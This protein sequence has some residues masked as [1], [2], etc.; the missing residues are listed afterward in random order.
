[1]KTLNEILINVEKPSRYIGGEYGEGNLKWDKFNYCICFPDIYEVAMSNLGIKIVEDTMKKVDGVNVDRCFAVGKDFGTA[2]KE[3]DIPLYSLGL[4]RPLKDFD[5]IGFSLSYEMSYTTVLYMLDLAG[6][7][8]TTEERK[9]GNWPI[10]QAGGVCVCNPEPLADF[11]DIFTIGDGEDCMRDLAKLALETK[12]REEFLRRASEEI[13]GV[14]VPEFM[15]VNYNADGTIRSF[16]SKYKVKKAL[17]KNL[18]DA[19]FPDHFLSANTEAVFDRGIIEVS[20]GCYRGCRFCQAG[21]VYRPVRPKK[22]QTLVKQA[23]S[24]VRKGG[25][26]ELSMNSLSTGDYPYLPQLITELK[27]Q[28]PDVNLALPSLRLDSFD[29]EFVQETRKNSLTF[30]PEAG[31]QRLRNV[32]NKD[33]DESEIARAID[34]AFDVGY[35]SIKLYFMIG[36]PT[37]TDEDLNGICDIVDKIRDKY[38]QKP[39]ILR[40]LRISISASTF[41]PKPFTPFQ[42]ERQINKE[43]LKHKLDVLRKRL[44]IKGVIVSWNDFELSQIE[45]VLAR[46]DRRLG[47]VIAEAYKNGAYLESWNEFFDIENWNKAFSACGL[48]PEIYTREYSEDEILPWDFIDMMI[49]KKFLLR[50]RHTAYE[51]KVTP[52][53]K[54]QCNACG[55][56]KEYRCKL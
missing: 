7:P 45:A 36:L 33:I 42:W 38:L 54:K 56:Q 29:S 47:K 4:K 46:G 21:F 18:D 23:C 15:T 22:V 31:T 8:L 17:C 49:D 27:E 11:F 43:E 25:F 50:E 51:S 26:D 32:I 40:G 30:A 9:D 44:F 12:S 39:K 14:Y 1:M 52:N 13:Q 37:E 53:C 5:M 3:N 2:L 34:M 35:S 10:I 55:I 6:I 28:L 24:I 20:R 41:I 16:E 19:A 48:T